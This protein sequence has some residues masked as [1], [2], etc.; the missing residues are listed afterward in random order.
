MKRLKWQQVEKIL[1]QKFGI[2]TKRQKFDMLPY[3]DAGNWI[4]DRLP[5]TT[6][7]WHIGSLYVPFNLPAIVEYRVGVPEFKIS[8]WEPTFGEKPKI[9]L[10]LNPMKFT[11]KTEEEFISIVSEIQEKCAKYRKEH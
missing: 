7:T 10:D 3:D 9:L 6:M 4:K 11:V 5:Y 8:T 1:K 2:K